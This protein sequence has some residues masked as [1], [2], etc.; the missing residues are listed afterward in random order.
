[1][2]RLRLYARED[3]ALALLAEHGQIV[4]ALIRGTASQGASA[5]KQLQELTVYGVIRSRISFSSIPVVPPEDSSNTSAVTASTTAPRDAQ[6]RDRAAL[7]DEFDVFSFGKADRLLGFGIDGVGFIATRS[8]MG[9]PVEMPPVS[10][11]LVRFQ[12]D[13]AVP[14]HAVRIVVFAPAQH[15]RAESRAELHALTAGIP[16]SA[17]ERR[18]SSPSNIGSPSPAGNPA[19][20]IRR[21]RQRSLPRARRRESPLHIVSQ[22]V[23]YYGKRLRRHF[24]KQLPRGNER[25]RLV[26]NARG[27][28]RCA[29]TKMPFLAR[30]C[31]AKPPATQ[32]GASACRKNARRHAGPL[33]RPT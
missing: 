24:F 25:K 1:M 16:N 30:I 15:R 9:A 14:V 10:R 21:R 7:H 29:P 17:A 3:F 28:R 20:R 8:T 27:R 6:R 4:L 5:P 32:I 13:A 18:F 26:A 11:R 2:S 23:V 19:P 31:P 33:F 12:G 22:S